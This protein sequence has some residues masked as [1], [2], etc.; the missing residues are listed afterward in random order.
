MEGKDNNNMCRYEFMEAIVRLARAKYIDTQKE[1]LLSEGLRKIIEDDI[2]KNWPWE[3]WQEFRVNQLWTKEVS[4]VF[5]VNIDIIKNLMSQYSTSRSGRKPIFGK[6]EVMKLFTRDSNLS[7]GD[8]ETTFF[9][10]MSK[11]TVV[12]EKND[13]ARYNYI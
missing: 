8:G 7:L 13:Y 6:A 11:M 9:Y 5:M 2:L 12:N 10:G 1:S 4:D 3:P